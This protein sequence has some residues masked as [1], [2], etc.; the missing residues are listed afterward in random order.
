VFLPYGFWDPAMPDIVVDP[1]VLGNDPQFK[2]VPAVLPMT[3][4]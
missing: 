4:A 1:I 3:F 2:P